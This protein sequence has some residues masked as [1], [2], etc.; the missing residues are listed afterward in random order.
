MRWEELEEVG[1]KLSE[2]TIPGFPWRDIE[3]N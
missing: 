3:E 1:D 2:N